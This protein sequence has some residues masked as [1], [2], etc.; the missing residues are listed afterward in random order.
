MVVA[1]SCAMF[2]S[3]F[4]FKVF[5]AFRFHFRYK[6]LLVL[7]IVIWKYKL[8][9]ELRDLIINGKKYE[10]KG[11]EEKACKNEKYQDAASVIR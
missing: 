8:K 6:I 4:C 9:I 2:T 5:S 3:C 11:M 7:F 10:N 1:F